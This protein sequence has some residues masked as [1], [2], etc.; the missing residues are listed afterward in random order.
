MGHSRHNSASQSDCL[1]DICASEG[2]LRIDAY[3]FVTLVVFD[4]FYL[5]LFFVILPGCHT[6]NMHYYNK[7]T[8]KTELMIFREENENVFLKS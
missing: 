6:M 3:L 4:S 8:F 5:P 1:R 2:S 7:I